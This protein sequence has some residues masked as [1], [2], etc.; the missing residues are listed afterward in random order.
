M[1]IQAFL[2]VKDIVPV[3]DLAGIAANRSAFGDDLVN[4]PAGSRVIVNVEVP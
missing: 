4:V 2:D 3:G 1:E